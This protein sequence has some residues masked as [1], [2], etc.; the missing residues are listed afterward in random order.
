M[1]EYE[2]ELW[3]ED[4]NH[5]MYYMFTLEDVGAAESERDAYQ[6]R[7]P[8]SRYFL[9]VVK[10]GSGSDNNGTTARARQFDSFR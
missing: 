6:E 9:K 5:N 4:G 10:A 2:Y 1:N 3:R 8:T 7:I